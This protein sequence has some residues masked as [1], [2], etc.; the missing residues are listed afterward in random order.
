[1]QRSDY[2]C[3]SGSVQETL[4]AGYELARNALAGE[5]IC[6]YGN[7]GAGKTHFTKGIASYFGIPPEEVDSP[8]FILLQEYQGRLPI[9]HFDA[10]RLQSAQEAHDIGFED[11]IYGDGIS[12]VEWPGKVSELLPAERTE[13]HISHLSG[14][15]RQIEVVYKR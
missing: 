8:T 14:Q 4:Q 2:V 5:L 10:Y 11:Y 3:T 7:L 15:Q 1:M 12:I 9:Y 13:V 6:L